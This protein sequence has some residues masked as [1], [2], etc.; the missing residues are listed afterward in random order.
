MLSFIDELGP[1]DPSTVV[2]N[3]RVSPN[4]MTNLKLSIKASPTFVFF[5]DR[6]SRVPTFILLKFVLKDVIM[7]VVAVLAGGLSLVSAAAL[8]A[9]EV[10]QL[11]IQRAFAPLAAFGGI[12]GKIGMTET[13]PKEPA[14]LKKF[15]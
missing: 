2:Y 13:N 12:F 11:Q 15:N 8:S 3:M 9:R 4:S 14:L 1:V 10:Q 6:L 5:F 7:K